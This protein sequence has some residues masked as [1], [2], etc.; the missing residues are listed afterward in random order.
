MRGPARHSI[1]QQSQA[2]DTKQPGKEAEYP[3]D[4]AA[5]KYREQVYANDFNKATDVT[6]KHVKDAVKLVP[7]GIALIDGCPN[8]CNHKKDPIAYPHDVRK[9]RHKRTIIN[10]DIGVKAVEM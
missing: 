7:S 1:G 9:Q 5:N 3:N 8:A 10:T 2:K 6:L 4:S